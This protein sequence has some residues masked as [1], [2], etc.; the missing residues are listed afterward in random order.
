MANKRQYHRETDEIIKRLSSS[1]ET[2]RLLLHCCCAPCS[3]SVLERLT[4]TFK[5]TAFFYNPNITDEKEYL[6]RRDELI[7]LIKEQPHRLPVD[8]LEAGYDRDLF[9]ER[10]KGL[11]TEPERGKR[12][13]V[14][15]DLRLGKT[16]EMAKRGGFGFF[17][18]TLTLSPLKNA[19]LINSIGEKW[20]ER[21]GVSW[22]PSDFKKKNGYLRSIE[23]S[24]KYG[25]YRQDHCGCVFS[26]RRDCVNI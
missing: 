8:L 9:F 21:E 16:A 5:V 24:E 13:T 20:A 3:S 23:L 2:P 4:D 18:T 26:K 12:C 19:E 6:F 22:L 25:L 15:F 1:N 17:A 11:E 10:V 7:R 14:C